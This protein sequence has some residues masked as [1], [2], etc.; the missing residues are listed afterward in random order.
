MK[1]L[2]VENERYFIRLGNHEI[3]P[4]EFLLQLYPVI[5][6]AHKALDKTSAK[7]DES[8]RLLDEALVEQRKENKREV[9]KL[10]KDSARFKAVDGGVE[11]NLSSGEIEWLLQVLNDVRVGSWMLLG[12]PE[13]HPLLDIHAENAVNVLGMGLAGQFQME[14]LEVI[15]DNR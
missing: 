1:L 8:Q 15:K 6:S 14:L 12:S 11:M 7:R 2:R 3:A 10:L 13:E 9:E 4:F 5:P